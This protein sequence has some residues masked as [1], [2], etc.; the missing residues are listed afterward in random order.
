MVL[1]QEKKNTHTC[2][3]AVTYP[4]KH[5]GVFVY[6]SL[7]VDITHTHQVLLPISSPSVFYLLLSKELLTLS[8]LGQEVASHGYKECG[9]GKA[10]LL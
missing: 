7:L 4:L 6:E 1:S 9:P 5:F 3:C 8:Q 2:A 10:P